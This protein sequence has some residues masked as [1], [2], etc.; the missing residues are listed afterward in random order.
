MSED[1][2]RDPNLDTRGQPE[3]QVQPEPQPADRDDAAPGGSQ[4]IDARQTETASSSGVAAT[5]TAEPDAVEGRDTHRDPSSQRV[6]PAS[7]GPGT[8]TDWNAHAGLLPDDDLTAYQQRWDDIQVG[9]IDEPRRSVREADDLVGE[10]THQIAQRFTNS[11]Q[12]LEQ[13]WDSGDE[14]TTEELRQAVQRYR[15]FFQR[16]VAR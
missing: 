16:L 7:E 12:G 5:T 4:R 1:P 11:R 13:R 9:F 8:T 6:E 10:V 2:R 15:D 3:P 14:P